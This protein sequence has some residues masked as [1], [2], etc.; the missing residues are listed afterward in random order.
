MASQAKILF[1][2]I[3]FLMA[4]IT[5]PNAVLSNFKGFKLFK[6]NKILQAARLLNRPLFYEKNGMFNKRFLHKFH[7]K[8]FPPCT[9]FHQIS[10]VQGKVRSCDFHLKT[11]HTLQTPVMNYFDEKKQY[12]QQESF[13]QFPLKVQGPPHGNGTK[14]ETKE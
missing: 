4:S 8:S 6:V 9:Y 3:K 1:L 12:V 10:M 7:V 13:S 2:H 11:L 14:A 5:H